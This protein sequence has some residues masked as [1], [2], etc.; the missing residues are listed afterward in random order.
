M[1]SACGEPLRTILILGIHCGLRIEAVALPLLWEAID[2]RKGAITVCSR[3]SKTHRA[4]TIPMTATVRQA[5]ENV[6]NRVPHAPA[7][8]VFVNRSG[9]PMKSIRTIFEKAREKAGLGKG[10][11]PGRC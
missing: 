3:D 10:G 4:R 7:D 5:L 9:Q 6:W 8:P 2:L 1:L 11:C